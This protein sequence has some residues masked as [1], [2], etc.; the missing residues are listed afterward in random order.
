MMPDRWT[1]K[2][3]GKYAT[4]AAYLLFAA[5]MMLE[6]ARENARREAESAV[7]RYHHE[8]AGEGDE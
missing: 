7:R 3:W 1:L 2:K 8:H 4:V 6:R 5:S